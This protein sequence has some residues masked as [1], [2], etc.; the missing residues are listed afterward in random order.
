VQ[1]A[2]LQPNKRRHLYSRIQAI[3]M[4]SIGLVIGRQDPSCCLLR[5]NQEDSSTKRLVES[6]PTTRYGRLR[7][8]PIGRL[9]TWV[10][11]V[12]LFDTSLSTGRKTCFFHGHWTWTP[13]SIRMIW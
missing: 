9:R 8:S 1:E 7:W 2:Q 10:K 4:M 11:A 12:M 3:T 5:T 13:V 6:Q